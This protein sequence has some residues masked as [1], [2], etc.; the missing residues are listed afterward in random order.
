MCLPKTFNESK[1]IAQVY[2]ALV[3]YLVWYLKLQILPFTTKKN[4][5][6]KLESHKKNTEN[7]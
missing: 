2:I 7:F 4:K 1:L 5:H 3:W 6:A